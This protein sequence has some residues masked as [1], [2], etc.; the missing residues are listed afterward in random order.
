M[1][2][3]LPPGSSGGWQGPIRVNDTPEHDGRWQYLPKLEVAPN[4]RLDVAYYDRRSDPEDVANDVS[5]QSSF[6]AG[7]HFE[8]SVRLTRRAFDSRIGFGSPHNLADLGSR[9]GLLSDRDFSL[10][11]WTDTRAG[12]KASNKQDL[13]RGLVVYSRPSHLSEPVKN[14][15]R[16]GG[17]ASVLIG[18]GMLAGAWRSRGQARPEEAVAQ[19]G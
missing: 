13:F 14:A 11:V 17:V 5:L 6:D 16:Y 4:G 19:E 10:A 1:V 9:L 3:S 15:L 8:P 12:T 18:L 7:K 2:W